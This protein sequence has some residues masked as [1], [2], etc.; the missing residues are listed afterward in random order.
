MKEGL[1]IK[2]ISLV[3]SIVGLAMLLLFSPC[4]V[5]NF[6]EAQLGHPQTE[7]LNKSQSIVSQSNCQTVEVSKATQRYSKPS[8]QQPV[9][10]VAEASDFEFRTQLHSQLFT[11]F[12]SESQLV[13][14]IPLYI[15]YQNLQIYA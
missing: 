1:E 8:V 7:V 12:I 6:V 15:L 13:P 2:K 14:D 5:R 11:P 3:L 9:F 10:L 4:K